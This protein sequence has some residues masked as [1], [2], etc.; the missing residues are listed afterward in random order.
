MGLVGVYAE[1]AD[2]LRCEGLVEIVPES[3]RCGY[4]GEA[5]TVL[6]ELA[7]AGG[8]E[9]LR[10]S[11][12]NGGGGQRF[13]RAHGFDQVGWV[14]QFS[15]PALRPRPSAFALPT[16]RT[17]TCGTLTAE[18][19]ADVREAPGAVLTAWQDAVSDADDGHRMS[20]EEL[21]ETV[22][23]A[24]E[25]NEEEQQP[26]LAVLRQDG[27][28]AGVLRLDEPFHNDELELE[29]GPCGFGSPSEAADV[30]RV[31]LRT[32]R[33]LLPYH[34][35]SCELTEQQNGMAAALAEQQARLVWDV[36]RLEEAVHSM[37]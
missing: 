6:R 26:L 4:G 33:E 28:V 19:Y 2:S 13:L 17:R 18:Y 9:R 27:G 15:L 30:A 16:R 14:K 22:F 24:E 8:F 37:G 21:R 25:W 34:S 35:F 1:D 31:L 36:V 23:F 11:V 3:R 10:V 12:P 20:A 7:A 32:V 5:L 29:G